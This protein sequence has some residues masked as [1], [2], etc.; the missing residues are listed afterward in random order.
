MDVTYGSG[1]ANIKSYIDNHSGT[2][3]NNNG[4]TMIPSGDAQNG[5]IHINTI[6]DNA[7]INQCDIQWNK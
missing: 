5:Y 4:T 1:T 3:Y 6:G 2:I 7:N